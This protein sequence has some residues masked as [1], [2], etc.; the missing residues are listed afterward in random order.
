[1]SDKPGNGEATELRRLAADVD[2]VVA[3]AA[4]TVDLGRRG[5]V[6]SLLVFALIVAEL[7]PW[8]GPHTGWQV[9]LGQ[10]GAAIPRLFAA[11]SIGFGVLA[12]VLALT[13]RRWWLTWVCA[14]G[15][16]FASVDGLLAV[17]SQQS[18]TVGNV[19]GGGPGI[20][21]VIALA[22]MIVLAGTWMRTAWSRG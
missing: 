13:T 14:M 3:K 16:W 22:T 21:L 1:M 10:G 8:I 17:W 19:R 20:G 9:L 6:I 11:T 5:F 12:S 15:G 2:G 4:K 18:S 7:L